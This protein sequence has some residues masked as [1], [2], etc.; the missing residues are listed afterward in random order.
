MLC[1][2]HHRPAL[3]RFWFQTNLRRKNSA[4][5]LEIQSGKTFSYQGHPLIML[6]VQF[7]C[8]AWSKFERWVHAENLW[9]ILKLVYFDSWSWQ[10]F[11]SN[12]DVFKVLSFSPE[13][14][15]WNTATIKSLLLFVASLFIGF[16]VER[17]VACQSHKSDFGW[18]GFHFSSCLMQKSIQK[19]QVILALLDSFRELHLE[20]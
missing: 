2:C 3:L 11:V 9:G 6:Y 7:L 15:K 10:T 12:C 16:L 14:T 18:D 4:S 20:W 1:L 17:C 5:Y 13:C 8:S 19:S